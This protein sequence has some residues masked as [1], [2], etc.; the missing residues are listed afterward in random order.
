[1]SAHPTL[2]PCR[3]VALLMDRDLVS[4]HNLFTVSFVGAQVTPHLPLP[5]CAGHVILQRFFAPTQHSGAEVAGKLQLAPVL[6][7]TMPPHIVRIA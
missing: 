5:V 3:V 2:N 7:P 4:V 6:L 1:M